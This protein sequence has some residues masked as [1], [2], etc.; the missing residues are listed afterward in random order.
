M[1]DIA[2]FSLG[3]KYR[4]YIW[5]FTYSCAREGI[6][7]L[8]DYF[9]EYVLCSLSQKIK[10]SNEAFRLYFVCLLKLAGRDISNW[11]NYYEQEEK[12]HA[13]IKLIIQ[14]KVNILSSMY[15]RTLSRH[16]WDPA[17]ANVDLIDG[18]ES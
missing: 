4:H 14:C 18:R 3:L 1:S 7:K 5:M 16:S 2:Y 8:K 13:A 12:N 17:I 9:R 6:P 11:G 10:D 15:L